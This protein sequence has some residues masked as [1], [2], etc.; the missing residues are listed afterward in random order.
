[1]KSVPLSELFYSERK[2]FTI[3][4]KNFHLRV[5]IMEKKEAKTKMGELL[6]LTM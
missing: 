5:A 2:E 4:S 3:W 1:M 6:S